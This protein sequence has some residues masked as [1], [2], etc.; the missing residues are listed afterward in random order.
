MSEQAGFTINTEQEV[1]YTRKER[2]Y[3]ISKR[4]WNRLSRTIED[5]KPQ[6]LT[7][8]NVAWG[9][10]GI[11]ASC[12]VSWLAG[13][14]AQILVIVGFLSLGVSICAFFALKSERNHFRSSIERLKEVF[15][16]IE[17]AIVSEPEG[18]D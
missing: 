12:L 2:S 1:S 11:G 18:T 9:F 15:N 16:D 13:S 5:L 17:S 10:L 8:S 4:D 7:W 14:Q 3:L 6:S